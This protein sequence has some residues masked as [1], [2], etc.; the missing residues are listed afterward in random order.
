MIWLLPRL[1]TALAVAAVAALIGHLAATLLRCADH[2]LGHR[3][4]AAGFRAGGGPR[5]VAGRASD[6]LAARVAIGGRAARHRLLGRTRLSD[7]ARV[8][9]ARA[10]AATRAPAHRAVPVGDRGVAQ[11]RDAA[12]RR[13]PH[14]VVQ[15]DRRRSP[16][17]R[18][19]ARRRTAADQPGSRAGLRRAPAGA[20]VRR[21]TDLCDSRATRHAGRVGA[22][23]WRRPAAVD[24]AGRDRARC[25]PTRCGATSWPTCRTR[26]ARR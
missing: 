24:H 10:G 12:R 26:S 15:L 25:A 20:Q 5:R 6:G 3:W 21:G 19:D 2:R 16:R 7:G 11:R 13:R 1:L 9:L 8:A 14:R 22:A 4:W 23:L 17:R 18:P